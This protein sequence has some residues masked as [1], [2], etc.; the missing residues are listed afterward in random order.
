MLFSVITKNHGIYYC[1]ILYIVFIECEL[2]LLPQVNT[3]CLKSKHSSVHQYFPD[4]I[5]GLESP[6]HRSHQVA[7]ETVK[8]NIWVF[9]SHCLTSPTSFVVSSP[10]AI[11]AAGGT[12]VRLS[13]GLCASRETAHVS[14][15]L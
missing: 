11:R 15:P 13:P 6:E 2:L 10:C 4:F 8:R 14:V 7:S 12:C 5:S 1:Y 9:G 3:A